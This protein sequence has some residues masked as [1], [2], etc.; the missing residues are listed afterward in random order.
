MPFTFVFGS[1][2]IFFIMQ[3]FILLAVTAIGFFFSMTRAEGQI[4]QFNGTEVQ[5]LS[6][7]SITPP[8]VVLIGKDSVIVPGDHV[9]PGGI[10]KVTPAAK[11]G[12]TPEL[13]AYPYS[14]T[15]YFYDKVK[16][17]SFAM[18]NGGYVTEVHVERKIESVVDTPTRKAVTIPAPVVK[19]PT[20]FMAISQ[21]DARDV[22][23]AVSVE[24]KIIP[25][26]GEKPR[27]GY[28]LGQEVVLPTREYPLGFELLPAS[29]GKG[30]FLGRM[31]YYDKHQADSLA[32]TKG[33]SAVGFL[34]NPKQVWQTLPS[35]G[36]RCFRIQVLTVTSESYL[37]PE[38]VFLFEDKSSGK[39]YGYL[40]EIFTDKSSANIA[41]A[42]VREVYPDAFIRETRW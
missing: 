26:A 33:M 14:V 11:V 39:W 8:Q 25:Q 28:V 42:K 10:F 12:V 9:D 5:M 23:S 38:G 2:L 21:G 41:L 22:Q 4:I 37:V 17:D 31:I 20:T 35:Q 16:A 18:K 40:V 32:A 19:T 7:D 34:H 3:R 6:P 13:K 30:I 36:T 27:R 1:F 29:Q 24:T 15:V